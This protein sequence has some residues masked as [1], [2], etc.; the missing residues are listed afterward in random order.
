[1][2]IRVKIGVLSGH[3]KFLKGTRH[4]GG[5]GQLLNFKKGAFHVALDAK[6]PILPIVI[7][8][9]EFLGPSRHDQFPGGDVQIQVLPAIETEDVSKDD[10]DNLIKKTRDC[11]IA[12]LN[13]Q[14]Q[15]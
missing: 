1:M 15:Q 5:G 12:A 9:Y 13:S 4:R 3:S 6:M 2:E 7:S 11:M 10:I 14:K 8:E